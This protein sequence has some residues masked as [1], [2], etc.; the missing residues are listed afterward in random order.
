MLAA[1]GSSFFFM[2]LKTPVINKRLIID[3]KPKFGEA[4]YNKHRPWQG[5]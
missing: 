3:N 2:D 5:W 1:A 4:G